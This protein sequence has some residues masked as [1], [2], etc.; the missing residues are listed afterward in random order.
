MPSANLKESNTPVPLKL[1][2]RCDAVAQSEIRAMSVECERLNGINLAQGVCDTPVPASVRAGAQAAID[3]GVNSYT[4][5]DGI[6]DLRQTLSAKMLRYNGVKSD[7]ETEIV[8]SSGSTGSFYS[9]CLALLNPGD[10]VVLF[11]PFY[12]YHLNTLLSVDAV[13]TFVQMHAPDWTFSK[14]DLEKAITR[15][16]RAIV[17]NT[18]GNPSGKVYT[19]KELQ[20][21]A[22]VATKHDLFVFT[23]EIY[24][25]FLYDQRKHIS[26]ATLPGM[27][28]RTV[29]IS[30]FSKTFSITG[31]RI[32]YSVSHAKWAQMIG[33]MSDLIYV[34]A[35]APLQAGVARGL[36]EL[37]DDYYAGLC[38]EFVHKRELICSALTKAGLTPCM[39]QGAYYVLADISRLPGKTSKDRAMHLLKT[40]GVACVPGEAFFN[41]GEDGA[42]LG[43]FCFAKTDEE[44]QDACQR[45]A[46]L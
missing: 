30:G 13:P 20:W 34:C 1:S 27:A 5:F 36:A 28:E 26:P 2:R 14:E 17:I 43:R 38:H 31:W 7:P 6:S 45:L 16:T 46:R 19:Q 41:K 12:G 10:G 35:P 3:D 23:D 33:Y 29:T 22:D 4:R 24:E 9:A 21:I 11:E 32:G 44:L 18:P 25:Y 42:Q 40:T 39:P 8:V 37:G 15:K